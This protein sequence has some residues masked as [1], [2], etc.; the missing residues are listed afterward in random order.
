MSIRI[1]VIALLTLQMSF[2]PAVAADDAAS[3]KK[4]Q[5]ELRATEAEASRKLG[6]IRRAVDKDAAVVA[7]RK[8]A[9][10]ARAAYD[11]KVA[12]SARVAA[13]KKNLDELTA[14]AKLTADGEYAASPEIK[15]AQEEIDL[16]DEAVFDADSELRIA[17]FV[18]SELRRRAA[19]DESFAPLKAKVDKAEEAFY[20]ARRANQDAEPAKA[21]RAAA[22]QALADAIAAK[23]A[24]TPEGA[25]QAKKIAALER[26]AKQARAA[27]D[28]AQRRLYEARNILNED[29]PKLAE[30]RQI[31]DVAQRSLRDTADVEAADERAVLENA[32][33]IVEETVQ[34]KLDA[35]PKVAELRKQLDGVREQI[36]E[37]AAKTQE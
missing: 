21:E 9:A 28:P 17:E 24:A 10:D 36:R 37:L 20:A 33:R 32:Q 31:I 4:R 19:R 16:A 34:A 25:A 2:V 15:A 29:N 22:S 23:V 13:A 5:E 11:A 35:D 3:L 27:V 6:E 14:A 8:A 30:Y 12:S 1:A 18:M 7:A 26:K